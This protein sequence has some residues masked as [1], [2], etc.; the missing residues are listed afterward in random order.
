MQNTSEV[1]TQTTQKLEHLKRKLL[2]AQSHVPST[3]CSFSTF[4]LLN[5][6][7][8]WKL[9]GWDCCVIR[10][11]ELR[12]LQ[13]SV[14]W[15]WSYDSEWSR[16]SAW[17]LASLCRVQYRQLWLVEARECCFGV[18]VLKQ[19]VLLL[20][21]WPLGLAPRCLLAVQLF[22]VLAVLFRIQIRKLLTTGWRAFHL[23]FRRS[24][25]E[26]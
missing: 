24:S 17:P 1:W 7:L 26:F 15:Y 25:E 6:S 19:N 11:A 3:G 16:G 14:I 22:E 20:A 10:G 4:L 12:E 18:L 2:T 23:G 5:V 9:L 8:E 21:A 13:N